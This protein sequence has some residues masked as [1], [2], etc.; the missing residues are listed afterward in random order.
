MIP[1]RHVLPP[2]DIY[3]DNDWA[4]VERR[5]SPEFVAQNETIFATANGYLGMRGNFLE[6]S[7]A[8]Q[9]GTFING[10]HETWP[11]PYGEEAYGFA[12]T[13]Q[14]MLSVTDAK[15]IQL[16]VDDEPFY[17]PTANLLEYERRLDMRAGTLDRHVLWETPAGKQV[18]IESRRVVSF[19]HRHLAAIQ[20]DVTVLNSMA[21]IA[22]VST[23]RTPTG[24]L[25]TNSHDPRSTRRFEEQVLE[26]QEHRTAGARTVLGLRTCRSGMTMSCA[27]DHVIE[28]SCSYAVDNRLGDDE[29]EVVVRVGAVPGERIRVV[30]YITYHSSHRAPARDLCD[31]AERT[32]DR[33]VRDGMDELLDTQQRFL[34]DFWH[35]CD[36]QV[37]TGQPR[38]QQYIRFNLFHILQAS[39]RAEGGGI[40]ARGLTGQTYEGHYFWD[41]EIYVLPFLIYTAPRIA[42]NLLWFRYTQLDNARIRAREVN[43]KGALFPWRT[44]TG[45]EASAFFPGGTAQYHIDADIMYALK[46]YVEVTGDRDFLWDYGAEMLVETARL[47]E[48]LGGYPL[49]PEGQFHIQGVTGPDEYTALVNDNA[50]TNLMARHNL[51]FAI[52]TVEDML[53]NDK[54]RFATLARRTG[55]RVSEIGDWKVAAERMYIPYDAERRIHPQDENFLEKEV[56]DLPNTPVEEFPLLLH[57]HP[58]VLYRYQVI[59]QADVVLA[60]FLLGDEFSREQKRRNFAYYDPLT[61]G[62]SSLSASIQ[63]IVAAEIGDVERAYRYAFEATVMDLADVGGN[64]KDGAHIASMGGTWMALVYGFAGMRDYGG[65]ISFRP[66]NIP[67]LK[68]LGFSLQ[69]RGQVLRVQIDDDVVTYRLEQGDGMTIEHCGEEIALEV[70]EPVTRPAQ[71][72]GE[73]VASP[74]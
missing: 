33:A 53:R 40:G 46:K 3:P 8:F 72:E 58:L 24:G 21:P 28:T 27:T 43:N 20:Y 14:T 35:R 12:K 65:R 39:G 64:V 55:L 61:T 51:R 73:A 15:L 11:I 23:M 68:K 29:G 48:D 41:A 71:E 17:L 52:E 22:I 44:I 70:G 1:R 56:W 49:G 5:F 19:E 50:Y 30:K 13:G 54:E 26:P 32:L 16:F 31:R 62:D 67:R 4:I 45:E 57:Y 2:V 36:V 59:K 42:R 10:F 38:A 7:P 34:D 18:L 63:S 69:V 47:W 74:A 60:M 6:G 37:D 25:P 9:A 66:R